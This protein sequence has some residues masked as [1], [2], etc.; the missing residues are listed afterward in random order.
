MT[1]SRGTP[2]APRLDAEQIATES[3][4]QAAAK[5]ASRKALRESNKAETPAPEQVQAPQAEQPTETPAPEANVDHAAVVATQR[6]DWEALGSEGTFEAYL[7]AQGYNA[8][9]SAST[10]TEEAA[11]KVVSP[12]TLSMRGLHTAA[13]HYVRGIHNGDALATALDGLSRADVIACLIEAMGL[14]GNPYLA[15]NPGQQSMNLRNKARG[16][17]KIDAAAFLAK[18]EAYK[19]RIA[20]TTKE[21]Q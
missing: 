1:K 3:K 11:E 8:D 19:A 14:P 20:P 13:K 15:L 21:Q 5:R 16:F 18:V 17:M 7:A 6:V 9:G 2:R 10:H 12:A 4:R